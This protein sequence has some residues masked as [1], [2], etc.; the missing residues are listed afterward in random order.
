[1]EM[2]EKA[3]PVILVVKELQL[4][5]VTKEDKEVTVR[6]TKEPPNTVVNRLPA[7]RAI[8]DMEQPRITVANK[9][10][11]EEAVMELARIT[12]ARQELA[13]I[14]EPV[15][16]TLL[17]TVLPVLLIMEEKERTT[18]VKEV[19]DKEQQPVTVVRERIAKEQRITVALLIMDKEPIATVTK[20][21][22]D[23]REQPITVL[24]LLGIMDKERQRRR[25][26]VTKEAMDKEEITV[27]REEV[28]K[29]MD[30]RIATVILEV[31]LD[32]VAIPLQEPAMAL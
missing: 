15:W 18:V 12:V 23:S 24:N 6:I 11:E 2:E 21:V 1:M 26:T 16:I 17:A 3:F 19:M 8:K 30:N 4:I 5:T 28:V 9:E 20:E 13:G 32:T 7:R 25:I 22:M 29:D 10:E 27:A 14:M 31:L